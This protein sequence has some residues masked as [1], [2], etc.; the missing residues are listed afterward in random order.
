MFAKT[1]GRTINDLIGLSPLLI[2]EDDGDE[3][4]DLGDDA[5]ERPKSGQAAAHTQLDLIMG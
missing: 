4:N 1:D 3:D 5:K 2:D